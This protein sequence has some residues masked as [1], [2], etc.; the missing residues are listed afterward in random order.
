MLF[1]RVRDFDQSLG[2]TKSDMSVLGLSL[3]ISEQ[4]WGSSKSGLA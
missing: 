2:Q 1:I 4:R 3:V